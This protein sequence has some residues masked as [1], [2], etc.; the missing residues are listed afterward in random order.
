MVKLVRHLSLD[1]PLG[2]F[3]LPGARCHDEEDGAL[4]E[5]PRP[6]YPADPLKQKQY[7]DEGEDGYRRTDDHVRADP[8][9]DPE[10]DGEYR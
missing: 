2:I 8:S 4:G 5:L 3:G 1:L 7:S 10:M 6:G 9:P